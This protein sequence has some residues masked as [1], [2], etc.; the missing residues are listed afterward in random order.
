M[1]R[2]ALLSAEQ[3]DRLFAVPTD[4]AE[5]ARHYVLGAEG[6]ALI[7]SKRR[8]MNRLGFA[9]QLCLLRYP[10]QGLGPGDQPPGVM[11]TFVADQVG[12]PPA[13]FADYAR[14][15][16]TRREHA[17]ELQAALGIR[18]FGFADWRTCIRVGADAAWATDRGEPIVRAMLEPLRV[19]RVL[20]PAATVLERIGLIA[21]VRARKT[22]FQALA[23]DLTDAERA[24]IDGLLVND[25][26]VH[27]SRFAWLRDHPESPAPSNMTELLHRLEYVRDLRVSADHAHRIHPMRLSRL[28][29]EGAIMSAQHITDLEPMRRTAILVAQ[30]TEL[31]TKLADATLAM[32]EKYMGSLFTKA[33][34]KDERRFSATKRDVAKALLL[35]RQTIL[36]LKQAKVTGEEGVSAIE[37]EI[38]MARLERALPV[39]ASVAHV[40]EQDIL[41]TAAEKYAVLRRFT[42]R[43]LDAFRFQSSAPNDPVLAAIDL[44]RTASG[45]SFAKRPPASFLPSRWRKLIFASGQAD[46]RLY[47]V[48]LLATLRDRLRG[49]D[50]WVAGSRDYRAFEDYLLPATDAADPEGI[51]GEDDPDRYIAARAALLHD[52]LQFVGARAATGDLDGVEI[53]EG[54]LYIARTKP[55]A[56]E[57]ARTLAARLESLLPRVR[58]TEVLADV[59]AWTGFS[60][61]FTHLRTGSPAA[62]KPALLAAILADGTNLGLSRMADASRGLTYH[63]LVNVAQWHINDDN[64][65]AARAVIINAHHKHPLAALWGDGTTSS[66]DGQYFRAGGRASGGRDVNA[67]YGIDPGAVFY[68]HDSGQYGSFG[69]RVITAT[70]SE[71]PYVLDGLHHHAHQTDLRIAEHYTD[72]AGATDHVFGLCHLLGYRFAPRIKDL[73]DRKLYT[74]EKPATY[75]QLEPLI[76][77]AVD[78]AA[79]VVQWPELIRLKRSIEVGTTIP[80]VIL[81]KLS[82]AGPGNALSRA[83][84]ALGRIERTLFTLQW[85]S[86]PA[87]RQRSHAGLNK[88]EASNALRRAIF[89]H[90]QGEIRD[91]TFENQSFRASG[92]SV[93][94][95]AIVHWNT[96]YLDR[97][98]QHLRAQGVHV[99]DDLLAHVA[100]LGW[101]HIAL[102]GDY[103]WTNA[104]PAVSFR[105][106]REVRFPFQSRAA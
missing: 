85:L 60:D 31:E 53:E 74:V 42:P 26:D 33:R 90:R 104:D 43:F 52:R 58:I 41:V 55:T 15:D 101:E 12:V 5:M 50:I 32:F 98:V 89:F 8:G 66:S 9:V 35:F 7:Q 103:V 48:A 105:P 62:D 25:P 54:K 106:L 88:G 20:I 87:L 45:R 17:A 30:V 39:I 95:A 77:D 21:R 76:G 18:R 100:P 34:G 44:L 96:V 93:L 61:R 70:Q 84:R 6:L 3:R 37:R 36:A 97:A 83:L 19:A 94:T 59:D 80:S 46:R 91:R 72:T 78:V 71:A 63:H 38:G 57:A 92:L 24:S 75:P 65:V 69:T 13:A 2:R 23:A 56:P 29:E 22:A 1:S 51:S 11:V 102:T 73:K 67:K 79:I 99:P 10:G 64:Y 16:Q 27:R 28:V 4:L 81:R 49:S 47:E 14:R 68:T 40:A 86:D 82:A